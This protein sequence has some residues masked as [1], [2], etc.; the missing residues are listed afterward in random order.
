MRGPSQWIDW[1]QLQKI[2]KQIKKVGTNIYKNSHNISFQI[3]LR[4][5][6]PTTSCLFF[7]YSLS[8]LL[9]FFFFFLLGNWYYL[10]QCAT[11]KAE[12]FVVCVAN[13]TV[14]LY[15]IFPRLRAS[16]NAQFSL[17]S[18]SHSSAGLSL[19]RWSHQPHFL[20]GTDFMSWL[21]S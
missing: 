5:H 1:T 10:G 9:Q 15:Y 12:Y 20:Y 13:K 11:K 6:V 8:F 4:L 2:I 14:Y 3:S 17:Q 19:L 21:N 7:N 18:H 16:H